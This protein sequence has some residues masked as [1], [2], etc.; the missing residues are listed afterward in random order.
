MRT[1]RKL[2]FMALPCLLLFVAVGCKGSSDDPENRK[3]NVPRPTNW[4]APTDYDYSSSMTVIIRLPDALQATQ[5]A[6]DL[7]AAFDAAGHCLGVASLSTKSGGEKGLFFLYITA[8][9][10]EADNSISLQYWSAHWTNIFTHTD[11]FVFATDAR[12]GTMDQ[13]F[14]LRIEN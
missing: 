9:A 10:N 12:Q 2:L 7:L 3:G 4:V 1:M 6:E 13:P 14:V 5:K 8:P 11:A